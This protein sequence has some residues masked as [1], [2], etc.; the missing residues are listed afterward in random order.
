MLIVFT[1]YVRMECLTFRLLEKLAYLTSF[2]IYRRNGTDF[3][4]TL[5]HVQNIW[6]RI[7]KGT[8]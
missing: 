7:F 1:L 6:Y 5:I 8:T 2:E 4:K 3:N